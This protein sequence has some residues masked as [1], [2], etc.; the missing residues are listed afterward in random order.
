MDRLLRNRRV[1]GDAEQAGV[2]P[3]DVQDH[4]VLNVDDS[5]A[6]IAVAVDQVRGV[7]GVV[8]GDSLERK[9]VGENHGGSI[10]RDN[11]DGDRTIERG[12]LPAGGSE[13]LEVEDDFLG[14]VTFGF[15]WHFLYLSFR[16]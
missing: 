10:A 11:L 15:E 6:E 7:P 13:R 3:L 16:G 1:G 9:T 8:T 4:R 2:F 5:G 12:R 14:G